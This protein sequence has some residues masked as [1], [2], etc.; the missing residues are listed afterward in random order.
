MSETSHATEFAVRDCA[1][2]T[3]ATGERAETL[4]ELRDTLLSIDEASIFQHVWGGL[5]SPRF[6]EREY[7]N[8]FAGWARHGLHDRKL[9]EKLAMVDPTAAADL[10]ELRRDLVEI[11]ED[12]L[13]EDQALPWQRATER[14]HFIRSQIVVFD[15]RIRCHT[16][17]GMAELIPQLSP[18]SLFY[19]FIDA[20]RRSPERSDDLRSWL[21][22][23]PGYEELRRALAELDPYFLSLT[24]LRDEVARVFQSHLEERPASGADREGEV[25]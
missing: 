19:H 9:A 15:T 8:D 11:I 14:F 18:S 25:R 2:I 22:M 12:R 1:L 7:N 20:R 13:D 16:P 10:A 3:I 24:E 6:G 17:E 4:K 23:F 21:G 5:L